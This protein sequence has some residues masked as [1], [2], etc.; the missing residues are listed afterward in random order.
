M[1]LT[2][3][4][5]ILMNVAL[6]LLVAF[7][8]KSAMASPRNVAAQ[9]SGYSYKLA[10]VGPT[11]EE[12]QQTGRPTPTAEQLEQKINAVAQDGWKLHSLSLVGSYMAIFE[13]GN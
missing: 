7:L 9:G 6:V 1:K 11:Q 2:K 13:R 8:I 10:Y 4:T 3:S 5:T 12:I